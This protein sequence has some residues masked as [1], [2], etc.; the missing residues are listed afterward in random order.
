M[1]SRRLGT[2]LGDRRAGGGTAEAGTG[3]WGQSLL[4]GERVER[5]GERFDVDSRAQ[6]TTSDGCRERERR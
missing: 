1:A 2:G 6:S 3:G 5:I 4:G